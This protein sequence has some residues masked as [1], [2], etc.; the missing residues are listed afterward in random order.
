MDHGQHTVVGHDVEGLRLDIGV[1]VGAPFEVVLGQFPIRGLLGLLRDRLDGIG[2]IDGLTGAC[3]V[4]NAK[5]ADISKSI[6][7]KRADAWLG[8]GTHV[9]FNQ[10]MMGYGC[11]SGGC[12]GLE[13]RSRMMV[14]KQCSENA[15][16][17]L[18]RGN[19]A[20]LL[21][22]ALLAVTDGLLRPG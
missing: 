7:P 6:S 1:L 18:I 22:V 17:S 15:G 2:A 21:Q 16:P 19:D 5:L 9:C 13:G 3:D 4:G 8:G 14:S 11:C 20:W 12:Q 10:F